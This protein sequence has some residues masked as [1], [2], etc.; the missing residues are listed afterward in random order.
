MRD[1]EPP[2]S[3][4]DAL[5]LDEILDELAPDALRGEVPFSPDMMACHDAL[6]APGVSR[7]E[8]ADVVRRWLRKE[9]PCLFG[10]MAAGDRVTY[11]VLTEADLARGDAH[12]AQV[13]REHRIVWRDRARGGSQHG[14]VILVVS[15]RVAEAEPGDVLRI[16]AA[17]VCRLY[18]GV[19]TMDEIHFDELFFASRDAEALRWPVGVNFFAAAG[20]RRWW[21]DHRIPGGIALSMNSVGHMARCLAAST[22]SRD[23]RDRLVNWALPT[24]MQ[25]IDLPMPHGLARGT[26][27]V[28]HGQCPRDAAGPQCPFELTGGKQQHLAGF[29]WNGYWGGYHTDITLPTEY[30]DRRVERPAGLAEHDLDFTYLH[31]EGDDDYAAMGM[32]LTA[33]E[34]LLSGVHAADAAGGV[35]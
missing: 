17:R 34:A 9:Q 15:R 1:E 19:D 27:L 25:T 21:H 13:I 33:F 32:G 6:F 2:V 11:C 24:A 7:G 22:T 29:S 35:Q 16:L 12:V 30:F 8:M 14:F 23:P 5:S 3:E 10:R 18:L 4:P 28:P 31:L 20:D 26:R